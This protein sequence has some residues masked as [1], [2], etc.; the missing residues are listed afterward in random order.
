MQIRHNFKT[1][2]HDVMETNHHTGHVDS[3]PEEMPETHSIQSVVIR[4]EHGT[5]TG[6][7]IQPENV[8]ADQTNT[9]NTTILYHVY[10]WGDNNIVL[11]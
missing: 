11:V 10:N 5:G 6:C 2:T 4:N 8:Q 1:Q 7:M 9:M 3:W